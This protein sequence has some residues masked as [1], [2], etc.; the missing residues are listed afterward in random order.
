[1]NFD[2]EI[3]NAEGDTTGLTETIADDRAID[4]ATW[5]DATTFL[6]G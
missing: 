4:V 1:M 6:L 3:E 2:T 5:L